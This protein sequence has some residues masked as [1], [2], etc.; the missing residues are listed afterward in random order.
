MLGTK[1]SFTLAKSFRKAVLYSMDIIDMSVVFEVLIS[2]FARLPSYLTHA[3]FNLAG[4]GCYACHQ[5]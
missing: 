1:Q 5:S 2:S 3:R 4:P